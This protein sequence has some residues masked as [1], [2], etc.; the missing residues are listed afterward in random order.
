MP[1]TAVNTNAGTAYRKIGGENSAVSFCQKLEPPC[2]SP[3]VIAIG[4]ARSLS[5]THRDSAASLA[6]GKMLY[7]SSARRGGRYAFRVRVQLVCIK[8]L[9]SD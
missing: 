4:R 3:N 9:G 8:M 6:V 1:I 2:C 5:Q 7:V